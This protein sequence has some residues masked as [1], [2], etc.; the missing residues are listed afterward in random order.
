M[1]VASHVWI[2][3]LPEHCVAPGLHVPWH[4]AVLPLATH[5][6]FVH[7]TAVP[8]FPLLSH[9]CTPWPEHW[10]DPGTHCPMHAPPTHAEFAQAAGA[11][12]VPVA[13][14]VSIPLFEQVVVVG[15]HE[16][17]HAPFEQA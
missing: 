1:P 11:P 9:V 6:E 4:D 16:P 17:T 8:Q 10:V 15:V 5:A 13:S 14:Q 3:E 2:E 7:E 12:N